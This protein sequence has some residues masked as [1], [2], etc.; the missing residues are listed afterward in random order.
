V[1][2]EAELKAAAAGGD[3][4]RVVEL[5]EGATEKERRAASI[6]AVGRLGM[7]RD[8]PAWG[9]A[10]LGT[11]TARDATMWWFQF[12]AVPT[13]LLLRVVRARGKQFLGTLVRAFERDRFD[14]WGLIRAAVK[15]GLIE[16]PESGAYTRVLVTRLGSR[17]FWEEAGVYDALLADPELLEEDVWRIFEVD[18]SQELTNAR[19]YERREPGSGMGKPVANGWLYALT[20]LAAEG[21]LDRQRV[22]DA[23]LGALQRDFRVSAVGWYAKLHEALEPTTEERVAR[24]DTYLSLLGSPAPAVVKEGLK[25]LK[26]I[27]DRMPAEEL[28]RAAAPALTHR[29]KAIPVDV[30]RLLGRAAAR[31]PANRSALLATAAEALGHEHAD[32]QE[33]ALGLLEAHELDDRIRGVVLGLAEAV[34]PPLRPR[35]EALSGVVIEEAAT[36]PPSPAPIV[37]PRPPL[38]PAT[39]ASLRPP[40]EP[41]ESVPDLIE[42][43]AALLEGQGTGD[44]AE[45]FLDGVSR[46]GREREDGFGR[47]TGSIVKRASELVEHR[48]V[49]GIDGAEIVAHV[50]LAWT[51]GRRPPKRASESLLGFLAL[52]ATEVADRVRGRG[53]PAALLA[54]PTHSGGWIDPGVLAERRAAGGGLFN[55]FDKLDLEQA[56]IR[57]SDLPPVRLEAEATVNKPRWGRETRGVKLRAVLT[58][59]ELGSVADRLVSVGEDRFWGILWDPWLSVDALGLRWALTVLPGDPE[60]M[61]GAALR[62]AVASRDGQGAYGHPELVLEHALDP[63]VR[64]SELGWKAVAAGLLGKPEEVKRA[65]VDVVVATVTDGR[66]DAERLAAALAWLVENGLG[67][68]SRLE[69]P[70]RDAGRISPQHAAAVAQSI[71]GFAAACAA[72]PNGVVG[73]LTTAHELAASVG[74]RFESGAVRSA[75]ERIAS[76]VSATSK[77]GRAARGLLQPVG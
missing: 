45:R 57:A 35:V 77:L 18:V 16:R 13:D 58:P 19:V 76:E 2:L 47:R 28:A 72:T 30:L 10:W 53:K 50:V 21:R 9:L 37:A 60:P 29:Q 17:G 27:E 4:E 75:L 23:S 32:V 55:R 63:D 36:Q 43:T 54:R 42:L 3:G 1:S 39:A 73:P 44:D 64:I 52:R 6:S 14:N 67:K 51:S 33:R 34:S 56:L 48:N 61:Y 40:V 69:Q 71:V 68:A 24:L 49:T 62:A 15:E 65:A 66:F 26:A 25:G 12:D 20:R 11:A 41:V 7:P 8:T 70:F 31:V 22:L 59:K 46:L 5:I 74:L 38:T